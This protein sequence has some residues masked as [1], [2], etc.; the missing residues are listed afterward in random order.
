[1]CEEKC[2]Y[3]SRSAFIFM[4]L[5][6]TTKSLFG[7]TVGVTP[8][9][10]TACCFYSLLFTLISLSTRARARAAAAPRPLGL[11]APRAP[12]RRRVTRRVGLWRARGA[13]EGMGPQRP[14][15]WSGSIKRVRMGRHDNAPLPNSCGLVPMR[16]VPMA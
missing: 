7:G 16:G 9:S 15:W 1:M 14:I 2:M 4:D 3:I 6:L 5:S 11:A 10:V 13:V 12:R 8:P